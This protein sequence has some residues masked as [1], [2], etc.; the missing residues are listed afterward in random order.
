MN[1]LGGGLLT[2]LVIIYVMIVVRVSA[3]NQF[4]KT[5]ITRPNTQI[6]NSGNEDEDP[7]ETCFL[8]VARRALVDDVAGD[9]RR[10]GVRSRILRAMP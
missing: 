7:S 4:T 10:D 1:K 5:K 6:S 2:G 9:D 8:P 3:C